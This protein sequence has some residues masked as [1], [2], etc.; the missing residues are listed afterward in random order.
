MEIKEMQTDRGFKLIKFEDFYDVKC[1]IQESSLATEEAIWF[2]VEDANPRILASKIKEGRTEW[3]KYPIPDDVLLST[4][5]HLTREQV[6][7][8]LPILQ[9][10]ADTGEI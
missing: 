7:E 1:N 2:G 10:F 5:M 8:L 3:A 6:K 9:K 4:R